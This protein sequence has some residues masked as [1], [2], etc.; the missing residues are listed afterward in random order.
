[1]TGGESVVR[2]TR[3]LVELGSRLPE[4]GLLVLRVESAF[5]AISGGH[6]LG[7]A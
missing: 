6:L 4:G 1:L 2:S 5:I 3:S 7:C